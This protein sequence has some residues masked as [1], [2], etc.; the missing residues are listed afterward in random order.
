M[1]YRRRR[2]QKLTP[3]QQSLHRVLDKA[4][5]WANTLQCGFATR[6]EHLFIEDGDVFADFMESLHE[7]LERAVNDVKRAQYAFELSM[8]RKPGGKNTATRKRLDVL[9]AL[10]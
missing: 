6:L 2:R 9:P 10:K 4:T 7:T 5:N 8:K 3:K 1:R